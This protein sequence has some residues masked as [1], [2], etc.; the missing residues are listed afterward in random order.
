[1]SLL[2]S[3]LVRKWIRACSR[4]SVTSC[5]AGLEHSVVTTTAMLLNA[6]R[7]C[8]SK[9]SWPKAWY[10]ITSTVAETR[11]ASMWCVTEASCCIT[12]SVI[13]NETKNTAFFQWCRP[14]AWCWSTCSVASKAQ[15]S[16]Y[17]VYPRITC[18]K[19]TWSVTEQCMQ[20]AC[21]TITSSV[22][23]QFLKLA[24]YRTTSS[25]NEEDTPFSACTRFIHLLPTLLG[26][27]QGRAHSKAFSVRGCAISTFLHCHQ[28]WSNSVLMA[29]FSTPHLFHTI[30]PSEFWKRDKE[31]SET[32]I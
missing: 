11:R 28:A 24:C 22:T 1:M 25:V 4:W 18:C 27:I 9:Y 23:R 19:I 21:Y 20:L 8:P 16:L 3:I 14:E 32:C 5:P 7:N 10:R 12:W 30:R 13:K 15:P 2:R 31:T 17:N 29:N 6:L 26:V